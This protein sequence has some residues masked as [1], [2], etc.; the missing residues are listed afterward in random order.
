MAFKKNRNMKVHG[1]SGENDIIG[2]SRETTGKPGSEDLVLFFRR[3]E[4]RA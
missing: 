3:R 1:T 2:L 4:A